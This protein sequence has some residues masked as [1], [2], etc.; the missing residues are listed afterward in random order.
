MQEM[1]AA[2]VKFTRQQIEYLEK[3]YPE[4]TILM[5][6]EQQAYHL[7]QRSVVVNLRSRMAKEGE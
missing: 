5:P 2:P 6:Y 4:T 1:K 7:G 3:L